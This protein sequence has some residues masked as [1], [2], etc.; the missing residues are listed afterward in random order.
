MENNK[1][2]ANNITEILENVYWGYVSL[3]NLLDVVKNFPLV[4]SNPAFKKIFIQELAR[5]RENS[6]G[7]NN[8]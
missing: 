5:R 6:M 1:S 7:I 2:L 4:R 8:Y 3:V